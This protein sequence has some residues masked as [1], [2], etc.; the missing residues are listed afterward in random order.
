MPM[1]SA[2]T[3]QGGRRASVPRG[4]K[5]A[6][7]GQPG[8]C[9]GWN[10]ECDKLRDGDAD[11]GDGG[12]AVQIRSDG[13]RRGESGRKGEGGEGGGEMTWKPYRGLQR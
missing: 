13:G 9:E 7:A 11:E 6:F 4:D 10:C 2:S 8:R 12:G 5:E 3:R 1:Q